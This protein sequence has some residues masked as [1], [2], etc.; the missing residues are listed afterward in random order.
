MENLPAL[1]ITQVLK[2]EMKPF[3]RNDW[4]G[5]AGVEGDGYIGYVK[6]DAGRDWVIVADVLERGTTLQAHPANPGDGDT[7]EWHIPTVPN[8]L[9]VCG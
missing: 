2:A 5:F 6:D 3:S 8:S 1:N 7:Y 4:D 9:G